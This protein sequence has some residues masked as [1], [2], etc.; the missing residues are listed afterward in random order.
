MDIFQVFIISALL[1]VAIFLVLYS[2]Y[3]YLE[4]KKQKEET[5]IITNLMEYKPPTI[6]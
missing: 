6:E 3:M 1:I 4:M 5:P 2:F